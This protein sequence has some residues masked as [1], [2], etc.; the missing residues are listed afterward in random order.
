MLV[1][2]KLQLF[3]VIWLVQKYLYNIYEYIYEYEYLWTLA[4]IFMQTTVTASGMC[5]K[6]YLQCICIV[7]KWNN[8]DIDN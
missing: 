5:Y 3:Q 7:I 8:N 2:K 6:T 4:I 1:W